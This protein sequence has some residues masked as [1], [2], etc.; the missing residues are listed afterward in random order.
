M[1][2]KQSNIELLIMAKMKS[3]LLDYL[4]EESKINSDAL[5]AYDTGNIITDASQEVQRMREVQAM[6][7]RDR[8]N[9][10]NRYIA[11]IKRMFPD[12]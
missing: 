7:L 4:T 5:K 12:G 2:N 8:V 10:L 9:E 6:I 3:I 1:G 11:V